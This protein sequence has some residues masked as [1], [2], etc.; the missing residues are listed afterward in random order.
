MRARTSLVISLHVI[1]HLNVLAP[2]PFSHIGKADEYCI[3]KPFG[4][5]HLLSF[6]LRPSWFSVLP[7]GTKTLFAKE[8]CWL[9]RNPRSTLY[10]AY[11]ERWEH[12]LSLICYLRVHLAEI[13]TF[14][15]EIQVSLRF[16][17]L[18]TTILM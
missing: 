5:K 14:C 6:Y 9:L 4:H 3:S 10:V 1:M 16:F 13:C 18:Y 7:S 8:L 2:R 17:Q 15:I 11:G 12:V